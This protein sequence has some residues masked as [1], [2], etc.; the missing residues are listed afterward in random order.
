MRI[1]QFPVLTLRSKFNPR[2]VHTLHPRLISGLCILLLHQH[3][4]PILLQQKRV[5]SHPRLLGKDQLSALH[6]HLRLGQVPLRLPAAKARAEP[7]DLR[8]DWN[9][10]LKRTVIRRFRSAREAPE[11]HLAAALLRHSVVAQPRPLVLVLVAT[12]PP[13]KCHRHLRGV[14]RPPVPSDG[15]STKRSTLRLAQRAQSNRAE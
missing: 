9:L 11:H 4:Q 1:D 2:S 10:Q 6:L 15:A 5:Q 14:V 12:K 3:H 7:A 8:Q 13:A